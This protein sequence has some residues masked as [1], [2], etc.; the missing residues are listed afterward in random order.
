MTVTTKKMT[1][2]IL[3]TMMVT[4][5]VIMTIEWKVKESKNKLQN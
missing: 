3:T 2:M 5:I 1:V 4:I